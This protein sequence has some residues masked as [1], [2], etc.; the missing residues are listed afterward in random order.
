MLFALI[1]TLLLIAFAIIRYIISSSGIR[2]LVDTYG[3]DQQKLRKLKF[4]DI[5]VLRKNIQ[6]IRKQ[7]DDF[8][9]EELVRKYRP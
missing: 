2:Y 3:M 5:A 6:K 7:N 9:L 8:S 4:K 1:S